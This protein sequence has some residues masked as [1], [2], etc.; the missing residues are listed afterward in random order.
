MSK[1]T[2]DHVYGWLAD[3]PDHRDSVVGF[4]EITSPTQ[5]PAEVDL[6]PIMPPVYDQ[7]QLGSCT[8]NAIAAAFDV[9]RH[10]AGAAFMSPSRLFIYFNE[11]TVEGTVKSD[12]GAQIRDGIKTLKTDG[13]APES[14]WP[15]EISKFAK[16]PPAGVF[17]AAL[18]NEALDYARVP[19]TQAAIQGVLAGGRPVVVGF[20][21]YE[22][23]ESQAVATTGIMPMPTLFEQALGGHAVLVVGYKLIGKKLYWIVRNSWGETWGDGGYFYMPAVYLTIPGLASDFWTVRTVEV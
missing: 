19:A 16:K 1:T 13:V 2:A 12:S 4:A 8:A 17:A 15:Y 6:R 10:I 22:S 7:G 21:V 9:A 14:L 5:L 18:K 20:T 11:R 3:T 23:F